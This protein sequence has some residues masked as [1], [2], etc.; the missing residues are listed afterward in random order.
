M[1]SSISHT[2]LICVV[3]LA[4]AC[5]ETFTADRDG[6]L[7]DGSMSLND[8]GKDV[9]DGLKPSGPCHAAALEN[10]RRV[11][12]PQKRIYDSTKAPAPIKSAFPESL[13]SK[14]DF[15]GAY[16]GTTCPTVHDQGKCGW[17]VAH[18]VTAAMEAE[19]C[20]ANG[21]EVLLSPPHLWHAGG[22][23][24]QDCTG[25]WSVLTAVKTAA[26]NYLVS[27]TVWPYDEDV[28]K[29][30]STKPT[31]AVLLGKG[32][33]QIKS[34]FTV[35]PKSVVNLKTA[36]VKGYNVIYMLPVFQ[37]MGWSK[38]CSGQNWSSGD[39]IWKK[40]AATETR[41]SKSSKVCKK[42]DYS[43]DLS[44][45]RCESGAD[46]PGGL[47]CVA[48]RCADGWQ[49]VLVI[50]YDNAKGGWFKFKNSWGKTWGDKGYG[51]LSYGLVSALGQGGIF[52]AGLNMKTVCAKQVCTPGTSK[53]D[54]SGKNTL[55]CRK[56]GCGW[57][58]YQS[59][60]CSCSG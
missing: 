56:D 54:A 33:Q 51:R 35:E 15:L 23:V 6:W 60:Q 55:K 25:E 45:C 52:P 9:S 14:I 19:H 30:A 57:D 22:K 12:L 41:C 59:C 11:C 24:V 26:S 34:Y 1:K 2:I 8:R 50:G 42:P 37:G 38:P 32:Q 17:T 10:G 4:G 39:V 18:S 47:A 58:L 27:R 36:L 16:L 7:G 31:S 20:K 44:T 29:M 48:G 49:A 28:S 13:P 53:C 5:D 46:C 21:V 3:L 43:T 40:P